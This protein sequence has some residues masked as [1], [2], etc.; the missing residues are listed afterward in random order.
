MMREGAA[1]DRTLGVGIVN[2]LYSTSGI[3]AADVAL[4]ADTTNGGLKVEVTGVAATNLRLVATINTSE[5]TNA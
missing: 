2:K 3:S 4:S 1:A 5:V